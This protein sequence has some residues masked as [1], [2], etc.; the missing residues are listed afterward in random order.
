M[1]RAMLCG[2]RV[3]SLTEEK[4]AEHCASLLAS[5]WLKGC[6]LVFLIIP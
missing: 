6:L 3:S 2:S 1:Q 4:I 5:H